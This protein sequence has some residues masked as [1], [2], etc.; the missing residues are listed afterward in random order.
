MAIPKVRDSCDQC[1]QQ[2]I[3]CGKQR[4]RCARCVSK[5]LDAC[6][7]SVSMRIGRPPRNKTG[8]GS[9]EPTMEDSASP[10]P[11]SNAEQEW[12]M[13][14][15]NMLFGDFDWTLAS[16]EVM[17]TAEDIFETQFSLDEDLAIADN[18]SGTTAD[19]LQFVPP[20]P[21]MIPPPLPATGGCQALSARRGDVYPASVPASSDCLTS[22]IQLLNDMHVRNPLCSDGAGSFSPQAE[23]RSI[24]MVLMRNRAAVSTLSQAVDCPCFLAQG[25]ILLASYL[26]LSAVISG[27]DA[28]LKAGNTVDGQPATAS[29]I[30]D[31]VT[32]TPMYMGSYEL[33]QAAQRGIHGRIVSTEL[34]THLEP[35]L[36]RLPK[37]RSC[38][39]DEAGRAANDKP[40]PDMA[41][42][43][44]A[45]EG[46]ESLPTAFQFSRHM[47]H[48]PL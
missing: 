42:P 47:L 43:A 27:Y 48:P 11:G 9:A 36:E 24:D 21:R 26:L 6:H 5:G 15:A 12:P 18:T 35:L 41:M 38:P 4:P 39:S 17:A 29:S 19:S 1:S 44:T 22:I 20:A 32:P 7:Y 16:G 30:S 33:D 2:K 40:V 3:K 14:N 8:P 10:P 23:S 25:C 28:I 34:K 45:F 37:F 46:Q 13:T 31:S